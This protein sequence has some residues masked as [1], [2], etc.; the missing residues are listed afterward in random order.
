MADKTGRFHPL[1]LDDGLFPILI[2]MESEMVLM[3]VEGMKVGDEDQYI[4]IRV[5]EVR[6]IVV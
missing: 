5:E 2:P 6:S 1:C 4:D 3:I